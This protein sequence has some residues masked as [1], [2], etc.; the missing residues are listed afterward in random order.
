M[1]SIVI[2]V[3][4]DKLLFKSLLGTIILAGVWP[5]G[6]LG[7]LMTVY[8]V[9]TYCGSSGRDGRS[10]PLAPLRNSPDCRA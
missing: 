8:G 2:N 6:L 1:R 10:R 7:Y 5:L 4:T 3:D 9:R